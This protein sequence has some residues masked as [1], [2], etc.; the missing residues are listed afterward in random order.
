MR[1][2]II[3][4]F[5]IMIFSIM[6]T[7]SVRLTGKVKFDI[8]GLDLFN[9]KS[10]VK[11]DGH[12][13]FRLEDLN[14]EDNSEPAITDL[15]LSFNGKD[16]ELR[17]ASRRYGIKYS[18]YNPVKG[19][20]TLGG[21]AAYFFK[22]EHYIQLESSS[23]L[24]LSEERDLG[25][26]TIEFKFCP[27]RLNDGAKIFSRM[28]YLSGGR[29]GIEISIKN[30]K[31]R[32]DMFNIFFDESGRRHSLSL[33]NSPV[34]KE[35]KWYHYLI[36]YDRYTGRLYHKIN[37]IESDMVFATE[38]GSA[39]SQLMV[40][41][42]TANDLPAITLADKYKGYLD[43]FRIIFRE[44]ENIKEISDFTVKNY[45]DLVKN[46]REPR[47]RE[48]IISSPVYILPL[49]G[50]MITLMKWEENISHD[51]FIWTEFRMSDSEFDRNDESLKWYRIENNQKNIYLKQDGQNYV[52]GKYFQWRTHLIASPD[53]LKSPE[54]KSMEI[55]Y[56][57][58]PAP[59]NPMFLQV[60]KKGDR[61]IVIRW[62]KNVDHDISGYRIYYGVT[63][64]EVD[65]ILNVYNGKY[66]TN[67][68]Q[69][70]DYIEITIDNRLIEENMRSANGAMLDFPVI[71]NNI[72]YY[73]KV[74]AY[75]SY[76]VGT[77]YNHESGFSN[78]V[79][80]RPFPGSE[81]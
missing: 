16:S 36:S 54:M 77:P 5:I 45:R 23:R 79:T 53:G 72:L 35:N 80:A 19:Q 63:P 57:L 55:S 13:Y 60:E 61:Q 70:G 59:N 25:S 7:A 2:Y 9:V 27:V 74:T 31:I 6:A 71:K 28:G 33:I 65:G 3:I 75:D 78:T 40:P 29:N 69:K 47:N 10:I 58:D 18:S 49:T 12:R 42:F 4:L 50:T 39:E 20:G 8:S 26:F 66:I 43:E 17:D 14:Y 51:T 76:K 68:I 48:G 1:K 46:S 81:I 67:E 56:E 22:D 38:N 62:K 34:L 44:Y 52:R 32:A 21:G 30:R 37:D 41:S 24:W 64:N 11:Q 73:I 15:S